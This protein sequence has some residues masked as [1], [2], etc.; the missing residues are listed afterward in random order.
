MKRFE[1]MLDKDIKDKYK[2]SGIENLTVFLNKLGSEG[3]DIDINYDT[4]SP[5]PG[6]CINSTSRYSAK[7]EIDDTSVQRTV[8]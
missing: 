5:S 6:G 1:Y 3:W 2:K 7:R 4:Y 8:R